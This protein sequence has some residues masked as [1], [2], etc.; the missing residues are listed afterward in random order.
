[1]L[2]IIK[3]MMANMYMAGLESMI[4]KKDTVLFFRNTEKIFFL[5]LCF[6]RKENQS[7]IFLGTIVKFLIQKREQGF[8]A[9]NIEIIDYSGKKDNLVLPN[10]EAVSIR[11]ISEYGIVSGSKACK[12]NGIDQNDIIAHDIAMWKLGYVFISLIRG[13][14]QY[15]I[16]KTSSHI[17]DNGQVDDLE[18]YIQQLAG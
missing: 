11:R 4:Q 14:G 8:Y 17:K 12:I 3:N 6:I 13:D 2:R 18:K 9:E 15:R 5:I 16:F 1:M 7:H 10:G